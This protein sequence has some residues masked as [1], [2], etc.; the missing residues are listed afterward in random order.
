VAAAEKEKKQT[1]DAAVGSSLEKRDSSKRKTPSEAEKYNFAQ[2]I[3]IP[4]MR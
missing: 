2:V 1:Q 3:H 4:R